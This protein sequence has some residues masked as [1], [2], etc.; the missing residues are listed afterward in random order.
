MA[1]VRYFPD[2]PRPA[3]PHPVVALGNFDGLHRGHQQLLEQIRRRS[4]EY[5][6]TSVV[7]VFDPHPPRV[8]RPDKAPALLMTLDQKIEAFERAGVDAVVV[9]RFTRDLSQW[10]PEL[11]VEAAGPY[12]LPFL[13]EALEG[14]ANI[15]P[16]GPEGAAAFAPQYLN[17]RKTSIY[18]GS[19]EIQKNIVSKILLRA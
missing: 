10:E 16:I 19:N 14:G 2:G 17:W 12:A 15:E 9:V 3:W 8:L 7:M 6:G 18:G 4:A 1:I 13:P 5:A 11:F